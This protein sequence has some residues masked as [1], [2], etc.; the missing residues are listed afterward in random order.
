M[1]IVSLKKTAFFLE[2]YQAGILHFFGIVSSVVIKM[3]VHNLILNLILI[4]TAN[5]QKI[6]KYLPSTFQRRDFVKDFDRALND[7]G[8]YLNIIRD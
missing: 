4:C 2:K 6:T 5:T 3:S 1:L 7:N 8:S